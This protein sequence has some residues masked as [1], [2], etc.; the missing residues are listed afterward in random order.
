MGVKIKIWAPSQEA[1]ESLR[2]VAWDTQEAT[3]LAKCYIDGGE[4]A[5]LALVHV[6]LV[7]RC[8]ILLEI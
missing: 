1:K 7:A 2:I 4:D 3:D 5:G 8:A 6:S